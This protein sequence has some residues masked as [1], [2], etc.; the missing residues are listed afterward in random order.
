MKESFGIKAVAL[1][2]IMGLITVSLQAST[3]SFVNLTGGEVRIDD[4]HDNCGR[5]LIKREENKILKAN[6][7]FK[8]N[9]S[10]I[11]H[12]YRICAKGLC[13][14]T[15]FGMEGERN[16]KLVMRIDDDFL[17]EGI[18]HPAIWPGTM[19]CP[20]TNDFFYKHTDY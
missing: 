5:V 6:E 7:T 16:Y 11:M 3:L 19:G 8:V 18:P 1:T 13:S 12:H 14:A 2:V 17:I 20:E 4:L 15:A 9:V 10:P